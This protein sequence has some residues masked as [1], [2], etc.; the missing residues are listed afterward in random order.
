MRTNK[1]S[2]CQIIVSVISIAI[3]IC[4]FTQPAFYIDRQGSQDAWS[5]S[6]FLFFLGWLFLL[7]GGL[8]PTLIWL[9]NPIYFL[10]LALSLK[11]KKIGIYL[12]LVSVILAII[13]SLLESIITSESG[14]HS[15]IVSLELGYKLW[16]TSFLV[17]AFGTIICKYFNDDS[18]SQNL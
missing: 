15:K 3:L 1:Y 6:L 17:L 10:S 11:G 7:G 16:L 12:S 8:I 13:F 4:S 18:N 2:S 9:A 14:A 5:N